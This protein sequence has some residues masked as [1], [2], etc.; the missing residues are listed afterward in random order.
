MCR[1][2]QKLE[3]KAPTSL[4]LLPVSVD[5]VAAQEHNLQE[6]DHPAASS[7]AS[8]PGA[9]LLAKACSNQCGLMPI[10]RS[11]WSW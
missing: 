8:G 2:M 4:I 6:A 3:S 10:D 1:N 9:L 5:R 7:G 11:L